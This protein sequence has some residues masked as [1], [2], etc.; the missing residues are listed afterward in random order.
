MMASFRLDLRPFGELKHEFHWIINTPKLSRESHILVQIICRKRTCEIYSGQGAACCQFGEFVE[1]RDRG[2][3]FQLELGQQHQLLPWKLALTGIIS[4]L[5]QLIDWIILYMHHTW[6]DASYIF[7]YIFDAAQI[8]QKLFWQCSALM[9]IMIHSHP[10][11]TSIGRS[12]KL[13]FWSL[14]RL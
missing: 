7:A 11:P 6:L 4:L 9:T 12:L 13:E 8:D 5:L 1:F 14:L 10:S 2:V 3:C